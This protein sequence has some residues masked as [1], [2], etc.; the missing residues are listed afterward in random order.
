MRQDGAAADNTSSFTHRGQSWL[1]NKGFPYLIQACRGQG[2]QARVPVEG[3][4][5][6]NSLEAEAK[7][8]LH[9]YQRNEPG[10]MSVLTSP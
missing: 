4:Q 2:H 1:M 10:Y 7:K 6:R 9:S 3:G 5:V 8:S